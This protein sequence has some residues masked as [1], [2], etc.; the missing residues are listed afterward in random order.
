M[1]LT[2]RI[3]TLGTA[4]SL[5]ACSQIDTGNVGVERTLGKVGTEALVPG[6]YFTLFK[7]V[8]EF[9]T[10]EVSFQLNDMTPKSRDNLTMKDVDIDIYFKTMPAAVPGLYIKYQGDVV[11]HNQIVQGGTKDL[12]MAFSRVSREARET[13]YKS[14]AEFDATTM[15]TKRTELAEMVRSRLQTELENNDKGAFVVTAVN[16]RNL[17]TDPAIEAAIRSRAETDQAIE[18]KR[19]EVELAK[20]EA[21][22]L[23]VQA[24]GEARANEIISA[25]LT[26]S[27]KEIK[28]A[29]IQRETA[30][31]LASK[32][33]NTVL[34]GGHATPLV[35]V[36]K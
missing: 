6:V 7:N 36:G 29:E 21:E 16:V 22:R 11:Q 26:P 18:K 3:L 20:A 30:L 32:P 23:I 9:T 31:A 14:M 8:D 4:L 25:S 33:G 17:L 19:K 15:H 12:V 13:V 10:K 2:H 28:L 27:L 5:A 34:L 1:T 35:N 24:Q